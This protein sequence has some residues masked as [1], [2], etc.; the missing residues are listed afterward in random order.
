[1]SYYLPSNGLQ[2]CQCSNALAVIPTREQQGLGSLD[3]PPNQAGA[4]FQLGVELSGWDVAWYMHNI[5]AVLEAVRLAVQR[6]G[7]VQI[8]VQVYS[9]ASFADFNPFIVIEGRARYAHSSASH[10]RDA[11]LPAVGSVFDYDSGSVRF[12]ADTYDP[13]TGQVHQD[14]AQRRYDAPF[15]GRAAPPPDPLQPSIL[16]KLRAELGI[17]KDEMI[18]LG[19]VGITAVFL[20]L[21][22]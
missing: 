20:A 9:K 2:D 18:V 21:R 1:M 22:R 7:F 15:G 10:L 3:L 8:P 4:A 13:A 16:D 19:V 14:P 6:G 5:D 12:E 11:L 17:G